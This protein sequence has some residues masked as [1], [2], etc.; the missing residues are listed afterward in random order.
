MC[1]WVLGV[2][3]LFWHD[4]NIGEDRRMDRRE[5]GNLIIL[6]LSGIKED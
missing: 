1:K 6:L 2:M 3:D 5:Q 4:S